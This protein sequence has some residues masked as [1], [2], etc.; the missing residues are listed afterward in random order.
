MELHWY[1]PQH[2]REV[3]KEQADAENDK[4]NAEKE[5]YSFK[6]AAASEAKI[7]YQSTLQ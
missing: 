4:K 1:F 6:A 5:I 2:L 3:M 7:I